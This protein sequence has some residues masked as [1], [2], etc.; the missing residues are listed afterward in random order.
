MLGQ[1]VRRV[2]MLNIASKVRHIQFD[3]SK[4]KVITLDVTGTLL[5]HKQAVAQAYA[6]CI[7]WAE[8]PAPPPLSEVNKAFRDAYKHA[9]QM[10]P[11]FGHSTNMPTRDWWKTMAADFLVRC[12]VTMTKT[13]FDRFF[14]RLYQHYGC[15]RGYEILPDATDLLN[16]V[17]KLREDGKKRYYLGIITNTDCRTIDTVLPMLG[18]HDHFEF[19]VCCREIGVE[20]PDAGIYNEAYLRA[21]TRIP[22]I[23]RE[24][25]LHIGDNFTTDFCGARAA[26][27]QAFFLGKNI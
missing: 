12:H 16:W 18:L 7:E 9:L 27:F 13:E 22:G 6:E 8:I 2:S 3:A 14:T 19:F 23:K 24:E 1:T 5:L 21:Q 20:K 26:G 10:Y 11:C 4:V 17:R 15:Q 25:I